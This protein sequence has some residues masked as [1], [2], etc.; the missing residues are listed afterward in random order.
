LSSSALGC[1]R[2]VGFC[3]RVRA[4]SRGTSLVSSETF[5]ISETLNYGISLVEKGS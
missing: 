4:V 2:Y 1:A 5:Q 3:E